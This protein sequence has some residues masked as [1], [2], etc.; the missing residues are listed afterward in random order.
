MTKHTHT[1]VRT[2]IDEESDGRSDSCL[3]TPNIHQTEIYVSSDGFEPAIPAFK[4]P[5]AH[6]LEQP[7]KE[8]QNSDT[9]L[10]LG[11]RRD[12]SVHRACVSAIYIVTL[13]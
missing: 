5:Q 7:E 12:V 9:F 13:H 8:T 2:A 6:A 4:C 1:H 11:N 3:T 10:T